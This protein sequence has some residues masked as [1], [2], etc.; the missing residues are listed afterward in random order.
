MHESHHKSHRGEAVEILAIGKRDSGQEQNDICDY[1][2]RLPAVSVRQDSEYQTAD[3]RAHEED[4]LREG[5][6]PGVVADP[7]HLK[8]EPSIR[9][10]RVSLSF[11]Q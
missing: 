8:Q 2:H 9:R 4:R 1:E 3:G 6:L 10:G 5:T 7:V 11:M